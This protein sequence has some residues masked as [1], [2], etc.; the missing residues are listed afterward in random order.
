MHTR[1]GVQPAPQPCLL[2]T[3]RSLLLVFPELH[4]LGPGQSGLSSVKVTRV[5]KGSQS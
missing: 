1:P 3:V 2:P 4:A 5:E